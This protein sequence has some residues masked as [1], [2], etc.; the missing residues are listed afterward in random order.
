[1]L[2]CICL[3]RV[4]AL[5]V[6]VDL[7]NS[8]SAFLLLSIAAAATAAAAAVCLTRTWGFQESEAK[9]ERPQCPLRLGCRSTPHRAAAPAE[10]A[11]PVPQL[12]GLRLAV[13]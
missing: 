11:G 5:F 4:V 7:A 9:A 10:E 13:R 1:M 12:E 3:V 8:C 6:P 2:S